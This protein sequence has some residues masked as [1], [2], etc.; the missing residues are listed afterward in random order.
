MCLWSRYRSRIC[1]SWKRNYGKG[2]G[3]QGSGCLCV[4]ICQLSASY[5]VYDPPLGQL[6]L[7]FPTGNT[8]DLCRYRL[9]TFQF[10]WASFKFNNK[11]LCMVWPRGLKGFERTQEAVRE[12]SVQRKLNM[13]FSG[14][15]TS[16]TTHG[17]FLWLAKRE[18]FASISY[19]RP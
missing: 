10:T 1:P 15:C 6:F 4:L 17:G 7:F 5:V 2:R 3:H 18:G 8:R 19:Q 12:G 13:Q 14:Q 9:S 11:K 16:R